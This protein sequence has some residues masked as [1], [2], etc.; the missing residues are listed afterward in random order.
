MLR[1]A[2]RSAVVLEA[3]HRV[4]GRAWTDYPTSLG[5]VWFD[6]GAVWFHDAEHNPLVPIAQAAG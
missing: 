2:G 3:S 6:M 4:G 1:E 5:G